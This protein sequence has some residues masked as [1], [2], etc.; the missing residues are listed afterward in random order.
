ME[1]CNLENFGGR[2]AVI[3]Q[4]RKE[5]LHARR[6]LDNCAFNAALIVRFRGEILENATILENTLPDS[7]VIIQRVPE[8]SFAG[9]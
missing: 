2:F 6:A 3:I 8:K 7:A 4:G 9:R 5:K 1:C